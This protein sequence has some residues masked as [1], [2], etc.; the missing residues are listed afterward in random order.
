MPD[1]ERHRVVILT[2]IPV[3]YQAVRAHLSDPHSET[4]SG[5][6][7][8]RGSFTAN[9]LLW[10]VLIVETGAGNTRAATETVRAIEYFRPHLV[11]FIGVAG[12]LKDVKLGDVVAA[13]KVY[14]Y[15]SGKAGR[16]FQPRPEVHSSTHRMEQR[17]RAEARK[18]DWLER[19][20][21]SFPD[22]ATIPHVYVA[23]IASGNQVAAST[24]SALGSLLRSNYSDAL[25]VEMEGYGFLEAVHAYPSIDALIIRGISDLID[26]KSEADAR[27]FQE[28]AARHATAFAFEILAHMEV[29]MH[30]Q[31]PELR[32]TAPLE[33]WQ[34]GETAQQGIMTREE[35]ESLS[36][37]ELTARYLQEFLTAIPEHSQRVSRSG[38]SFD[39]GRDKC[40]SAIKWLDYLDED[41]RRICETAPALSYLDLGRLQNIRER[42]R[43]LKSELEPFRHLR[44][45]V[46]PRQKRDEESKYEQIRQGCRTLVSALDQFK[47][48]R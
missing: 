7:Y 8:E 31:P 29:A 39:G 13:T 21:A 43:V 6:I 28:I 1:D 32:T 37:D 18:K 35:L 44:L 24:G 19:L 40:K 27:H 17:A 33:G 12:G 23:P 2:A 22:P 5:T 9:N 4:Y 20:A 34:G 3:E 25:A 48:Q 11:L 10:D 14:G 30:Q 36:P 26:D 38:A 16:E 45:R 47:R 15:E 41:V 42:I 46:T